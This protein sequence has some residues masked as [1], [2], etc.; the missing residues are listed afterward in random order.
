MCAQHHPEAIQS[1]DPGFDIWPDW[2]GFVP[3]RDRYCKVVT[4]WQRVCLT[5]ETHA[6][7]FILGWAE[8]LLISWFHS[9][10]KRGIWFWLLTQHSNTATQHSNTAGRPVRDNF[11]GAGRGRNQ[12]WTKENCT[13]V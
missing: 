4:S 1:R 10:A 12:N 11:S 5:A 7:A 8:I 3:Q 9:R 13:T 6:E 2:L